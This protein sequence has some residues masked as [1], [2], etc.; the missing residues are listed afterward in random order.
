MCT[1]IQGQISLRPVT[2]NDA[3]YVQ[4]VTEFSNDAD[5]TVIADQKYKKLEFFA[6]MKKH[7]QQQ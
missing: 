6:D 2:D 1:S 4:W 5:A 7:L 3:T